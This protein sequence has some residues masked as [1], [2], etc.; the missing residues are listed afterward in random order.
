MNRTCWWF[1]DVLSRALESTE[2]E[3]V[4]GDLAESRESGPRA[5]YG[6]AGLVA[7]RQAAIWSDWRPWVTLAC[8][9]FPIGVLLSIV[10]GG[11]EGASSTYGWLY[12]HNWAWRLLQNRAFWYI[13]GQ[14]LQS[15]FSG[16]LRIACLSW[17]VGFLLGRKVRCLRTGI[18]GILFCLMLTLGVLKGAPSYWAFQFHEIQQWRQLARVPALPHPVAA[19]HNPVADWVPYRTI[20][21]LVIVATFVALP[22]LL[23]VRHGK[24][25][26]M[27]PKMARFAIPAAF[28][29]LAGTILEIPGIIVLVLHTLGVPP[30]TWRGGPPF[31]H[32]VIGLLMVV[33]YWPLA[34]LLVRIV[35][36]LRERRV[37]FWA[38]RAAQS[39]S[40]EC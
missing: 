15:L 7:R 32:V 1:A 40:R 23:G 21:P 39:Q 10:S 22:A 16:Y 35:Q 26:T 24:A 25:G 33:V 20:F 29:A 30:G 11:I 17:S 19:Q 4:R 28:L 13:L 8:V 34:Y 27:R 38:W 6:V 2:G 37:K 31:V 5:F 36:G 18:L 3:A 12:F 14:S 9:L